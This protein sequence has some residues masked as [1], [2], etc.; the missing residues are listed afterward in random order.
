M[1]VT[2]CVSEKISLIRLTAY[3]VLTAERQRDRRR[4]VVGREIAA[5]APARS[6]IALAPSARALAK[7]VLVI[8]DEAYIRDVEIL[9]L[10]A[11]GY[12]A[13]ALETAT[14]ALDRLTE[15]RPDLIVLDLSLP[16][17]NGRD[18]LKRLRASAAWRHLS[19]IVT[20]GFPADDIVTEPDTQVL[21]KPFSD[22]AL[23]SRVRSL[24]G[25][26]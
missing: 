3:T 11:V 18:F 2:I 4:T 21:P 23:V 6:G 26:A 13:M 10:S 17:M 9:V 15:I 5:V 16:G 22:T 19:V 24:I 14:E 12:A 1:D 25:E 8:D 7:Q 20:S